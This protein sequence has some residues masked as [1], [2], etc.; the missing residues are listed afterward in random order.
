MSGERGTGNNQSPAFTILTKILSKPTPSHHRFNISNPTPDRSSSSPS[1]IPTFSLRCY[2]PEVRCLAHSPP[3]TLKGPPKVPSIRYS[4]TRALTRRGP[5][6]GQLAKYSTPAEP[7]H[8]CFNQVCYSPGHFRQLP[9]LLGSD[10]RMA[11]GSPGNRQTHTRYHHRRRCGFLLCCLS[12]AHSGTSAPP[13][14]N[15]KDPGRPRKW[16]GCHQLPQE[17]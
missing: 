12:G 2:A 1:T 8:V 9:A 6:L 4:A 17:T 5:R 13:R 14:S 15:E 11:Q 3:Q 10:F 7:P 16:L